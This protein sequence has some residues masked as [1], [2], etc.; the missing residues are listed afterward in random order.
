MLLRHWS[1][2]SLGLIINTYEDKGGFSDFDTLCVIQICDSFEFFSLKINDPPRLS[3]RVETRWPLQSQNNNYSNQ[4]VFVQIYHFTLTYWI[5]FVGSV[6]FLLP[7]GN[8]N[9]NSVTLGQASPCTGREEVLLSWGRNWRGLRLRARGE[10]CSQDSIV[11]AETSP[12]GDGAQVGNSN[13]PKAWLCL[14]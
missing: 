10:V 8:Q 5:Y 11:P 9:S 1:P 3:S 14:K 2:S 12:M 13:H 6:C 7:K 4:S